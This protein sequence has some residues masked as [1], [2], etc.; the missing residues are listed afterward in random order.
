MLGVQPFQWRNKFIKVIKNK[1]KII[2]KFEEVN[3][4]QHLRRSIKAV[5]EKRKRV[6]YKY[7]SNSNI[8]RS[9]HR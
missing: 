1:Q 6:T 4:K 3:Q 8:T 2:K 9:F 7:H 5:K